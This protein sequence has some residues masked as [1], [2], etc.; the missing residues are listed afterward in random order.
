LHPNQIWL[1]DGTGH[2]T[3]GQSLGDSTSGP[4]GLGDLDSDGD[5]DVVMM[6]NSASGSIWLNDGTGTFTDTGQRFGYTDSYGF[7]AL[8]DVDGDGDLDAFV[9][10]SVHGSCVWLNDGAGNFSAGNCYPGIC[11]QHVA[12]SDLE[13]DGDLDAFTTHLALTNTVWLNDGTA[14]FTPIDSLFGTGVVS[15]E[16]G[17]IDSDGDLDVF[18]GRGY[19]SGPASV[20]FN[21]TPSAG[22]EDH[23]ALLSAHLLAQNSPNPFG[24]VTEIC[25]MV[26]SAGCISLKLF[27]VLGR[28][29]RTLVGQFQAAGGYSVRIDGA[30][31]PGGTYFY[32]LEARASR[33]N[34]VVET[35]KMMCIR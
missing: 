32:R 8:G 14:S 7:P 24:S 26:P 10:N 22:V 23:G 27:D 11:T 3:A 12:L 15:V 31:L 17:D 6:C 19:G 35:R 2:F 25:Y 33:G 18:V 34:K 9:T 30:D 4:M 28:E 16:T 13:G 29:L 20:Y 1:N 21:T 5:V